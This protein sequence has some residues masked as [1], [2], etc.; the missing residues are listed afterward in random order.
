MVIDTFLWSF[1]PNVVVTD[2]F[3]V[4]SLLPVYAPPTIVTWSLA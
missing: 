1:V 4:S 3:H 2:T